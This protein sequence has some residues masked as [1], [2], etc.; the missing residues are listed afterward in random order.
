MILKSDGIQTALPFLMQGL[1]MEWMER[2][3][4]FSARRPELAR[5]GY[6]YVAEDIRGRYKSEGEFVMMRPLADHK[7]PRRWTRAPTPMTRWRGC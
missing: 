5:E 6:I 2:R 3:G 7:D 1:L 4:E